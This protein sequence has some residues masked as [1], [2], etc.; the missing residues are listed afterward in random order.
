MLSKVT[1]QPAK[2]SSS[3]WEAEQVKILGEQAWLQ[4]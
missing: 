3:S 4:L 1:E 2:P